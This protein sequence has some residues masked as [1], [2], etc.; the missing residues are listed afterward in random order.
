VSL[1]HTMPPSDC[2]VLRVGVGL[3]GAPPGQL[4]EAA[5]ARQQG[6]EGRQ[7]G[8]VLLHSSV[9]FRATP[10][11]SSTSKT[12][13]E[14]IRHQRPVG[15]RLR[16]QGALAIL[17]RRWR[18]QVGGGATPSSQIMDSVHPSAA[19]SAARRSASPAGKNSSSCGG[20][21]VVPASMACA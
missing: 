3:A 20:F 12:V 21:T 7:V 8:R 9:R 14:A 18:A 4:E 5:H 19:K 16:I 13:L 15:P 1:S 17:Q 6:T 11:I 10:G 2:C